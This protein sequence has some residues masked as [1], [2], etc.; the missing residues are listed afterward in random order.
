MASNP[1][2]TTRTKHIDFLSHFGLQE[3]D[4]KIIKVVH[5]AS[6][7]QSADGL[8]ANLPAK[9]LLRDRRTF[10]HEG[11]HIDNRRWSWQIRGFY[12]ALT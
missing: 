10:L 1:T 3:I 9:P 6:A 2:C 7:N 8:T 12:R 11:G 5:P 4:E